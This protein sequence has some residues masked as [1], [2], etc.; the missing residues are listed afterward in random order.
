MILEIASLFIFCL[1]CPFDIQHLSFFCLR[2]RPPPFS[3][4]VGSV[5]Q[6]KK[7]KK[8]EL[9][10]HDALFSCFALDTKK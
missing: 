10:L 9:H 2:R 5:V 4:C 1:L 3:V 8:K 7:K 6:K